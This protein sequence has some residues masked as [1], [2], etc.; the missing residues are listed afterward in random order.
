MFTLF[1]AVCAVLSAALV[2]GLVRAIGETAGPV[3]CL[4]AALL[5]VIGR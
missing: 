1:F 2:M 5:A 4:V 3:G